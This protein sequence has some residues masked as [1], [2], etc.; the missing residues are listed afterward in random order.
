MLVFKWP[1]T[2]KLKLSHISSFILK[3]CISKAFFLNFCQC[4]S[5]IA[6]NSLYRKNKVSRTVVCDTETVVLSYWNKIQWSK[7][8]GILN[9]T[10]SGESPFTY[11]CSQVGTSYSEPTQNYL[12]DNSTHPEAQLLLVSKQVG[13]N[14]I[15]KLKKYALLVSDIFPSLCLFLFR[16]SGVWPTVSTAAQHKHAADRKI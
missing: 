3:A 14:L 5:W 12:S 9:F 10:G 13:I 2:G 16:V 6:L 1:W 15:S 11:L 7:G 8:N 4:E